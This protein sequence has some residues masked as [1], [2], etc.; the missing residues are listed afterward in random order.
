MHM[1]S[2]LKQELPK[3]IKEGVISEEIASKIEHYYNSQQTS[4]SNKLFTIFGIIGSL[5]VGLGIILIL[6]HNWDDFSKPIKTTFAFIPLIV[7]QFIVGFSIIKKKSSTWLESSGVF[8]FFAVGSSISLVSQ[9]YNIPGNL[10]SFL[11]G[12]LLLCLPLVYLLKSKSVFILCL[13]FSTIYACNLGYSFSSYNKTPW[14]YLFLLATLLPFYSTQ[15]KDGLEK[16]TTIVFNWLFPLSIII[17]LGSF[18][19]SGFKFSLLIYILLFGFLYNLGKLAVFKELKIR[20]NGFLFLGSLGLITTML[21]AS[22]QSF[23]GSNFL[24]SNLNNIDLGISIVIILATIFLLFYN[25]TI[26]KFN[27]NSL[28]EFASIFMIIIYSVSFVTD[29]LST[30]FVNLII[31]ILGISA[32]KKG[33]NKANFG[34]LNYGLLIITSLIVARFLDTQMAFYIRG[35]LFISVGVGFFVANYL[36]LKKIRKNT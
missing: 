28:F 32:I 20:K 22:S 19:N 18:L 16:N 25:K 1:D 30:F 5:L 4:S 26:S 15:I 14:M 31:F 3:L 10:N 27:W 35:L 24:L 2:K 23:W 7:G 9:I 12:W 36:M 33:V 34:I 29:S 17:S 21:L 6:A 13:L 8:L 11:L